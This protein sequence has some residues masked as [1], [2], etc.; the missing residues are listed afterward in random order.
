[1]K[2]ALIF[3]LMI[4]A[5]LVIAGCGSGSGTVAPGEE[6]SLK[7][8]ESAAIRGE[9][10]EVTFL[11]VVE[12]S[13]CPK[14]VQCI[15]AG[16]AVSLVKIKTGGS[17]ENLE[18]TQPGVTEPPNSLTY[19]Q[20]NITFNLLPYPEVPDNINTDEYRLQLTISKAK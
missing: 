12:D 9:D 10:L 14:N 11:E 8:G 16:R 7:I 17:E 19:R 6:F 15:W 18:L 2:K 4:I 13:R 5:G 1:M 20:Y 3:L